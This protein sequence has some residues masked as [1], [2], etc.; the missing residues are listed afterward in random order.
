MALPLI[1][2]LAYIFNADEFG[3]T[4]TRITANFGTKTTFVGIFDNETVPV[5]T[6]GFVAVHQEQ[7]RVSCKTADIGSIQEGDIFQIS[8]VEYLVK[9]WVHDGTGV[10]DVSLEKV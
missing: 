1:S 3:V 10:T 4:V 8:G 7:P 9:S 6:G 2:D 5:E